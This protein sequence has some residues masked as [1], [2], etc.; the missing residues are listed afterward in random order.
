[1]YLLD[2]LQRAPQPAARIVRVVVGPI[3][4]WVR[5]LQQLYGLEGFLRGRRQQARRRAGVQLLE[6]AGEAVARRFLGR[7]QPERLQVVDRERRSRPRE[8]AGEL[9]SEGDR[10]EGRVVVLPRSEE[11]TSELQSPMYLVC[12]L[13]LEKKK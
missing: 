10:A 7:A 9:R 13:L 3:L 12:R 1:M 4:R 5:L 6:G 11:H 8:D 2:L